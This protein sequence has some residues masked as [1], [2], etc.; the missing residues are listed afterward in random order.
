M[1]ILDRW[2]GAGTS[3]SVPRVT[4]A[5][6]SN[7][8]FSDFYVED[9]SFARIQTITLGYTIPEVFT[10][11]AGIGQFRVYGKVDNVYTFTK[12]SGYDPTA[13]TG[14]PIGGGIDYGFYPLPRTY[15]IGVNLQ[16]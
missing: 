9:G 3:T 16:F 8:V 12:Y 7:A 5:P 2:T 15:I 1:L 6:T 14:A 11:K 4:T 10:D 13:S